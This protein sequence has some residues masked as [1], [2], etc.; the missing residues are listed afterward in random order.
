MTHN[1]EISEFK[2]SANKGYEVS[3]PDMP[4]ELEMCMYPHRLSV[5]GFLGEGECLYEVLRIDDETVR[6]LKLA[7]EQIADRIEY[8]IKAS[9]SPL[10]YPTEAGKVIDGKYFVRFKM[11][12]GGQ[13]CPWKD[14]I[15]MLFMEYGYMDFFVENME[16]KEELS[17]PGGIVH[18]IRKHH[19]YEGKNSPY[20]VDPEKAIR[21]LDIK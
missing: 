7:H 4:D 11:W 3:P 18:L 2:K 6:R 13:E 8:F 10:T 15:H 14:A 5:G 1:H 19:F 9:T 17:F 20:R 21:V 12:R 16:T